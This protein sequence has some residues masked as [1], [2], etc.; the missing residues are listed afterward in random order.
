MKDFPVDLVIAWCRAD[1]EH[2]EQKA[3]VEK[4]FCKNTKTKLFDAHI[5]RFRDNSELKFCLRSVSKY[6]PWISTIYV[7]VANYQR[8]DAY[9]DDSVATIPKIRI[10]THSEMFTSSPKLPTF[11]SQAIECNLHNI[12]GLSEHF[13]YSNDDMY[14]GKPLTRS[15]F[16]NNETGHPRNLLEQSFVTTGPKVKGMSLHSMAWIN[17]SE[18]LDKIFS[19]DGV[20]RHYP[21]HVM[22]PLLRSSFSD[23]C[24]H[25]V[26]R[27]CFERTSHTQF[28]SP[29]D[30]YPIGFI[31]Y[32]NLLMNR[33]T[34][35]YGTDMCVF[36][37]LEQNDDAAGLMEYMVG[38]CPHLFCIN[39]GGYGPK[40]GSVLIRGLLKLY[41]DEAPWEPGQ[42]N[43]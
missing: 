34:A 40:E 19:D 26:V 30:I 39:D 38:T 8:P 21:S 25:P 32:W 9:I 15:F 6:M 20:R 12:P 11:N 29:V 17:N 27:F 43:S 4:L 33:A 31:I 16:F 23:A 5:T 2:L 24:E 37:D 28:R 14:I 22:Q 42:I 41:P 7:V 35:R 3:R 10:I 18:L 36:H 13:I 1:A